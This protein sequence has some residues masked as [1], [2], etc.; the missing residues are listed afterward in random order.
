VILNTSNALHLQGNLSFD[1]ETKYSKQQYISSEELDLVY[2]HNKSNDSKCVK[3]EVK[4]E[5]R[6][7]TLPDLPDATETLA[8]GGQTGLKVSKGHTK[9]RP[10]PSGTVWIPPGCR[11]EPSGHRLQPPGQYSLFFYII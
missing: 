10:A 9:N 7:F 11:K 3:S 2:T 8:H 4:R 1:E 5:N 6:T